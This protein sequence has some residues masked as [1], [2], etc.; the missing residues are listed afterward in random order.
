LNNALHCS[1]AFVFALQPFA[2][3]DQKM[4]LE[5]AGIAGGLGMIAQS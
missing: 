5:I 1:G 2:A 4:M 3:I